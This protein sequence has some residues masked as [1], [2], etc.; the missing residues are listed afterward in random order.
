MKKDLIKL[1][2]ATTVATLIVG[3]GSSG[4]SSSPSGGG[5]NDSRQC[6]YSVSNLSP[7]LA[8]GD[9]FDA[10]SITAT[11][12]KSDGSAAAT[13]TSAGTVDTS[14]A[15]SY[16]ITF[17]SSDCDNTDK[18]TVKVEDP[19]QCTYTINSLLPSTLTVGDDFNVSTATATAKKGADKGDAAT[20]TATGVDA[21]D[22]STAGAYDIVF[23]STDC[24]NTATKT[25]NVT[26]PK[27]DD[28]ATRDANDV[29]PL[30]F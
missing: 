27:D 25:V 3:C 15:G 10:T 21:V 4:S 20:P 14:K 5:D 23:A 12:T 16:D 2:T 24:D 18:T 29:Q 19:R 1:I 8:I 13:P 26:E 7:L 30:P 17:S 6:T 22:T 28:G 9:S 11:A